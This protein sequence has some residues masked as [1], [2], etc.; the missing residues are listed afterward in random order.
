[1]CNVLCVCFFK[2]LK[3]KTPPTFWLLCWLPNT[4]LNLVFIIS[5][6]KVFIFPIL[7][8][9]VWSS[10]YY[11]METLIHITLKGKILLRAVVVFDSPLKTSPNQLYTHLNAYSLPVKPVWLLHHHK[12]NLCSSLCLPFIY[13]TMSSGGGSCCSP[14]PRSCSARGW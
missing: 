13:G 1:M 4:T 9:F 6:E 14:S 8:M 5:F 3:S 12:E 2:K 10:F 7:R 11:S